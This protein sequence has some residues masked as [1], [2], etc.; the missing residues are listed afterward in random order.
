MEEC[1]LRYPGVNGSSPLLF[2][3][4]SL[5]SNLG[6][7]GGVIDILYNEGLNTRGGRRLR[8]DKKG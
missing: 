4:N 2:S 3:P 8:R 5:S 7:R 6:L 1:K